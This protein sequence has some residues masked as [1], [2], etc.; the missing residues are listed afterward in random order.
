[1][2]ATR[3]ASAALAVAAVLVP[4]TPALAED[5]T[6]TV[7]TASNSYGADR[8]SFSYNVN[9]GGSA[10]DAMVVANR[11]KTPLTLGVYTADGF[12]TGTGQLDL[13]GQDKKQT[14][15]GAWVS[16]GTPTVVVPPGKTASVP[17]TVSVP[18]NATPGDYAGG[19]VTSLTQPSDDPGINVERR[20]GIR[21]KLRVG[22]ALTPAL[23]IEDL[24]VS[25]SGLVNGDATVDFTVHNSG[26]AIL[27]AQQATA[28]SGPFG[29]FKGDV[30]QLTALPSLLPGEKWKVSVPARDVPPAFWLTASVTVT[31]M[32]TDASGSTAPL[33][34]VTA[35]AHGWAVSWLLLLG[36][37]LVVALI[38][39]LMRHRK[40]RKQRE[41]ARVRDA[42]AA[43]LRAKETSA[44]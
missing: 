5:V 2:Y 38:V 4:A 17:F 20:L 34:A 15:I 12:T 36:I 7:R 29:W 42:V 21:I 16:A 23:A 37:V 33:K 6:W 43:A 1:M 31:P 11:G 28:V 44:S 22:G 30:A 19:I 32:L 27:S 8:S 25:W 26:N 24:R 3:L 40:R 39:L 41:D 18:A 14:G 9:P 35:T 10:K 13:Q